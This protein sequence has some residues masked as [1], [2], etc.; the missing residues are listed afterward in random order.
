MVQPEKSKPTFVATGGGDKPEVSPKVA[1]SEPISDVSK[2]KEAADIATENLKKAKNDAEIRLIEKGWKNI[3]EGFKEIEEQK[4][5]LK[6]DREQLEKEKAD[7][8]KEYLELKDYATKA[9]HHREI[10]VQ[11][12]K[13]AEQKY[14]EIV[15]REQEIQQNIKIADEKVKSLI[16]SRA[17]FDDNIQ[18]LLDS[19]YAIKTALYREAEAW[20]QNKNLWNL[21]NYITRQTVFIERFLDSVKSVEIPSALVPQVPE[22]SNPTE[23][24][25]EPPPTV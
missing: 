18:P 20:Q 13:Q 23:V 16:D 5:K 21:Y 12:Q 11:M 10:S 17:Y 25:I 6:A 3:D 4:A 14:N 2:A 19:L 8:G 1:T 22:Q 24:V 7:Y 15:A 9:N